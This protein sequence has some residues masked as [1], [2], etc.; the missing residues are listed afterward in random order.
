MAI[1][2]VVHVAADTCLG[3]G[4]A[5]ARM[6]LL[7][8]KEATGSWVVLGGG[9]GCARVG[10]VKRACHMAVQAVMALQTFCSLRTST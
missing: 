7:P 2:H 10:G 9:G 8:G 1:K 4:V 5:T 6:Y 3:G